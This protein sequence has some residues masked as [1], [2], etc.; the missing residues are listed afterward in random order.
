[1][2]LRD[3]HNEEW[4]RKL[5]AI[6]AHDISL[7][8]L[9]KTLTKNRNYEKIPQLN[10]P[11]GL[12][13]KDAQ[14]AEAFADTLKQTFKP[15]HSEPYLQQQHSVIED[16]IKHA[17]KTTDTEEIAKTTTEKIKHIIKNLPKRKAP[18]ADGITNT[19]IKYLPEEGI[20]ALENIINNILHHR[21]YPDRWK[22]AEIILIK[23]PN[24]PKNHTTSYPPI[25]L[26]SALSKIA[27][28]VIHTRLTTAIE[29][30]N[31]IPHQQFGFRNSHSTTQQIIRLTE[32]I[33][34]HMNI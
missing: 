20:K 27:E 17:Q 8:K 30:H 4:D 10:T 16:Y 22:E 3:I 21:Y 5:Q 1:M 26:L 9:T 25:S 24:K 34:D 19:A 31:A 11:I 2:N 12:V 33:N 18:G 15:N 32:H 23:K 28:K 29:E 7:W 13:T 6:D 14:K